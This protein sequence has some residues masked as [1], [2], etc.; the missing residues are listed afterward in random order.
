MYIEYTY[1][2]VFDISKRPVPIFLKGI[3]KTYFVNLDYYLET[4]HDSRENLLENVVLDII[5]FV[6]KETNCKINL[7]NKENE[8]VIEAIV[9]WEDE[10]ITQ[11]RY[12]A[13]LIL[14]HTTDDYEKVM[15]SDSMLTMLIYLLEN[16]DNKTIYKYLREL[17]HDAIDVK[18][19]GFIRKEL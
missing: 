3:T 18:N 12:R 11:P 10:C 2:D 19:L 17:K 8:L 7:T 16:T 6:L 13:L 5:R 14:D 1:T 15:N 4:N 9:N